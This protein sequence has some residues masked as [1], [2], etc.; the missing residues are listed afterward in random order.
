MQSSGIWIILI[1][2]IEA[3]KISRDLPVLKVLI[4]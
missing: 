2:K 4:V 1:K 3:A